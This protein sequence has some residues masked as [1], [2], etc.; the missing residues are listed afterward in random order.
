M[1][2][3]AGWEMLLLGAIAL[4]VLLWVGPGIK[5]LMEQSRQAK[6]RDWAGLL[7]PIVLVILFVLFLIKLV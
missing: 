5:P 2:K 3:M 7:L 4:L 1:E 6:N